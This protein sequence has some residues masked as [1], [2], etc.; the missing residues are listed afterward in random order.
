[1][2]RRDF[3]KTLGV[4]AAFSLLSVVPTFADEDIPR[5]RRRRRPRKFVFK[6]K[7]KDGGVVSGI[8]IEATDVEAAKVKLRERYK[9][10]EILSVEEK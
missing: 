4:T 2:R 3:L 6:I 1:M 8:A 7:T 10:S 9:N 5:R